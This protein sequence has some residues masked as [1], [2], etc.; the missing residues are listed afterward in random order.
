MKKTVNWRAN[1]TTTARG[2]SKRWE[3]ARELFLMENP[4]CAYC[5]K[6]GR[7]EPATIVDHITP[8]K[9]DERLFWDKGNWQA[10]C[11]FC[12]DS[13]KKREENGRAMPIFGVD[14]FPIE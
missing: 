2:Y 5:Q 6:Q 3:Q 13:V 9:G 14:G 7:T 1:R 4:L 10:L 11:K 12:H 8:H